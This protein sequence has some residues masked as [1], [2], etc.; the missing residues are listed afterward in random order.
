MICGDG[1]GG[2]VVGVEEARDG[3][4]EAIAGVEIGGPQLDDSAGVD[5]AFQPVSAEMSSNIPGGAIC[6]LVCAH[7]W[8]G[9]G[10]RRLVRLDRLQRP[11]PTWGGVIARPATVDCPW[12][13][14]A[15]MSIE[16]TGASLTYLGSTETVI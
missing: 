9:F 13:G 1:H 2:E 11:S 12:E 14:S 15:L 3:D 10:D 4:L 8:S 16:G 5:E 7:F 6:A